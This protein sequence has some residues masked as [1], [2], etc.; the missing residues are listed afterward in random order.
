VTLLRVT[1]LAAV[2]LLALA[3][4]SPSYVYPGSDMYGSFQ[5]QRTFVYEV[6]SIPGYGDSVGDISDEEIV[7]LGY[8]TCDYLSRAAIYGGGLDMAV[9]EMIMEYPDFDPTKVREI[10]DKANAYLCGW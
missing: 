5:A 8:T 7:N 1:T 10:M 6:R 9:V 3:A 4:C 2:C